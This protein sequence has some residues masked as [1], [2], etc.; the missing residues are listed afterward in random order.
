MQAPK[1]IYSLKGVFQGKPYEEIS[2]DMKYLQ[3]FLTKILRHGGSGII[4]KV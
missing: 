4:V 1:P 2:H 3:R